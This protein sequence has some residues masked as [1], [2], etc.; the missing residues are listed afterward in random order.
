MCQVHL[1]RLKV[2]YFGRL[3]DC[4]VLSGLLARPPFPDEGWF[5]LGDECV[6]RVEAVFV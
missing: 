4:T 6:A 1:R 3:W 2:T 5:L